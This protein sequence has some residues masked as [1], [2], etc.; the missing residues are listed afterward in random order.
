MSNIIGGVMTQAVEQLQQE[1][2]T[3]RQELKKWKGYYE[4]LGPN[5]A[6]RLTC[7]PYYRKS[8]EQLENA[9]KAMRLR[10]KKR[11]ADGERFRLERNELIC[12]ALRLIDAHDAAN[13]A[14]IAACIE[15]L[16]TF[17]QKH[18]NREVSQTR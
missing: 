15:L 14:E 8:A 2:E 17:C 9:L 10:N 1:L 13:T 12:I 16:R 7:I 5:P 18:K 6:Y 4:A 11:F 3:V